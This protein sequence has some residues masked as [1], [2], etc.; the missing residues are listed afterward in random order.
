[1]MII[2]AKLLSNPT[3]HNKVMGWTRTG[4]TE[5]YAQSLRA[6]CDLD[7]CPSDMILVRDTSSCHDNNLCQI[8][9]K[10]H[11]APL[12][13]VGTRFWNTL[14]HTHTDRV[15]SICLYAILWRGHKNF[16]FNKI[17]RFSRQKQIQNIKVNTQCTTKAKTKTFFLTKLSS[18]FSEHTF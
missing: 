5:V 7:I 12:I 10:S 13:M 17:L 18:L 1:M 4:F 15:D 2:C 3:M 14:T 9:F 8:I 16:N 6:Y 11:H